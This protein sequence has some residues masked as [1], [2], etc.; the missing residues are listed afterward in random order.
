MIEIFKTI[1]GG[2]ETPKI[3]E[4][5]VTESFV[6]KKSDDEVL[7]DKIHNEFDTA[8]ERLL[9]EALEIINENSKQKVVIDTTLEN[10]ASRLQALGFKNVSEVKKLTQVADHNKEKDRVINMNLKTAEGIK[11]YSD[12]YPFLKFLTE[13]ELNRICSKYGLIYA[14]VSH[15]KMAVPDKNLSEIENAQKLDPMDAKSVKVV[16]DFRISSTS[17]QQDYDSLKKLL[18][19][20]VFTEEEAKEIAS[21][22]G[23]DGG[24]ADLFWNL[25]KTGKYTKNRVLADAIVTKQDTRGLFIAAPIQYFDLK[26]LEHDGEKGFFKTETK[27]IK[28]PIVFRYVKGGVQV[29][30]KW[31]T[32]AEDV[33]LQIPIMN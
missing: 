11:Y 1:F 27:V 2:T 5:K 9:K 13:D 19:G 15:Y 26:G 24:H 28:D 4:P 20:N 18:G 22:Y 14:P 10:K 25:S 6:W 12:K 31:G 30:S 7:V 32:E 23:L 8:P 16:Y 29:L 17:Y 21:K 33:A 3:E